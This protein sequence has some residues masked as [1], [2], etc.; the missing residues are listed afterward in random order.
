MN[1]VRKIEWSA[2]AIKD[3]RR[4]AVTERARIISK[5]EQYAREPS[6]FANQVIAL[7]G[8]E[9]RRLRVGKYRVIFTWAQTGDMTI[10]VVLRVRHRR[11]AYV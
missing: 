8:S 4:I 7:T 2:R 3:M 6:A 9:Y 1:P 10:M 11:E 5:V